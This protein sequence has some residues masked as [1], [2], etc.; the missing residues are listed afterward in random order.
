MIETDNA[1]VIAAVWRLIAEGPDAPHVKRDANVIILAP[2]EAQAQAAALGSV[3]QKADGADLVIGL[4][5]QQIGTEQ[6]NLG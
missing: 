4:I 6:S 2:L 3:P 1:L 5:G